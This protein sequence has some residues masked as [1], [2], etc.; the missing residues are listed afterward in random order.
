MVNAESSSFSISI[1]KEPDYLLVWVDVAFICRSFIGDRMDS[2]ALSCRTRWARAKLTTLFSYIG[3]EAFCLWFGQWIISTVL[4]MLL[5]L[6]ARKMS[7][8]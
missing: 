7:A 4:R 8:S 3:K 6:I 5:P 2:S 1:E